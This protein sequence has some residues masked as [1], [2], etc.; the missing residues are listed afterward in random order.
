V[1][2]L[3]WAKFCYNSAFQSSL[4]TSVFRVVYGHDPPTIPHYTSGTARVPI[5][6]QQLV[7][8]DKFLGEIKDRLE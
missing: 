6:D 5:V 8:C 7:D 2:W 1:H 4:R 3:L